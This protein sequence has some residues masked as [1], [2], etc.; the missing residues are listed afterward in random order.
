MIPK[1]K[2]P[3]TW[4]D[5]YFGGKQS[6]ARRSWTL[7][8]IHQT[9]QLV[10]TFNELFDKETFYVF[11]FI[12]AVLAFLLAFILARYCNIKIKEKP[13]YVDRQWRNGIPANCFQFPWQLDEQKEN[14]KNK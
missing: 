12:F 13:I 1:T 6:T 4:G 3:G 2:E 10:P 8:M 5:Y 14:K 11:A 7:E 9:N